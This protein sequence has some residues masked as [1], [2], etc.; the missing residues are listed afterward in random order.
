[1][2][3]IRIGS[4]ETLLASSFAEPSEAP[5]AENANADVAAD[6][7]ASSAAEAQAAQQART[8]QLMM[9]QDVSAATLLSPGKGQQ[10]IPLYIPCPDLETPMG[11]I[12]DQLCLT[13][14]HVDL[15]IL[16]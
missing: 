5:A 3:P 11:E 14:Y 15:P 16:S 2:H 9:R 13:R 10:G 1:M 4:S 6:A 7:A 12:L 8:E